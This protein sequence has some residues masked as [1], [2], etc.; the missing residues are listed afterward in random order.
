LNIIKLIILKTYFLLLLYKLRDQCQMLT[1]KKY[2]NKLEKC[3]IKLYKFLLL[4]SL[5]EKLFNNLTSKMKSEKK[6]TKLHL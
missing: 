6:I 5:E 2:F 4:H 3:Q 1:L